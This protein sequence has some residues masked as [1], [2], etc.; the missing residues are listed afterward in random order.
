MKKMK[1]S[2][3]LGFCLIML[4][5]LTFKF[6]NMDISADLTST[7]GLWNFEIINQDELTAR[8]TL[9]RGTDT[10]IEVPMSVEDE[11]NSYTVTAIS[12]IFMGSSVTKTQVT[13]I[14]F[15]ITVTS[16]G[17]AAFQN[18]TGL[19]NVI[20]P[21]DLKIIDVSAFSGCTSLETI[22]IPDGIREIR[23]YAFKGCNKLQEIY[24]PNDVATLG[25]GIY[26]GCNNVESMIVGDSVEDLSLL[27]SV[28]KTALTYFYG[29]TSI[30]EIPD[31]FFKDAVNLIDVELNDGIVSIGDYAFYN[32]GITSFEMRTGLQTVGDYAFA[33]CKLLESVLCNDELLSIG[34]YAFA[35]LPVVYEIVLNDGLLSIGDY[36]MENN[37]M[38]EILQMPNTVTDVGVGC[39]KNCTELTQIWFSEQLTAVPE[40]TFYGCS[41]VI[42]LFLTPSITEIGDRAFYNCVAVETLEI[43][44]GVSVIGE[45]AFFGCQPIILHIGQS[46]TDLSFINDL[47]KEI[48]EEVSV[49]GSIP[50]ITKSIFDGFTALRI[51][52]LNE[53]VT[54]IDTEA[55]MNCYGLEEINLPL[56]LETI[57]DRAF[58]YC[59]LLGSIDIPDSVTSIG[60]SAFLNCETL[61]EVELSEGLTEIKPTTFAN[62]DLWVIDIPNSVEYI[63]NG[64]FSGNIE[65]TSV[66]LSDNLVAIDDFA[67]YGDESITNLVLPPALQVIGTSAFENC[68]SLYEIQLLNQITNIESSAFSACP[69]TS[70]VLGDSLTS[71]EVLKRFDLT[72]L[73]NISVGTGIKEITGGYFT[74]LEELLIVTLNGTVA[75][76]ENAFVNCSIINLSLPETLEVIEAN[77]FNGCSFLED[78][79]L[80][81][82]TTVIKSGAF[83]NSSVQYVY[84]NGEYIIEVSGVAYLVNLVKIIQNNSPVTENFYGI[85]DYNNDRLVNVFDIMLYK[86]ALL[87]DILAETVPTEPTVPTDTV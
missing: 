85:F 80:P 23:D 52:T 72:L 34:D 38:L 13:N 9:Y 15:P 40:E 48:L 79:E 73:N 70:L 86:R 27:S 32:S 33:D 78:I 65:L 6:G 18:F 21:E 28:S 56:T 58:A 39:F 29:G 12:N 26:D 14:E 60:E 2:K 84:V 47:N 82:E 53:N 49:G 75:I 81:V 11:N 19:T 64:A 17:P 55:F 57:G 5:G 62:C 46:V 8:L 50:V 4:M 59:S 35:N 25:V 24:I 43:G 3:I 69:I 63:W 54:E 41:N 7:D 45:E 61:S 20:L 44:D 51:V 16:I 30:T 10:I 83:N 77:A 87:Q 1:M 74:D 36:A 76:R 71:L 31:N 22:Y 37:T 66:M 68:L 67:F 42:E